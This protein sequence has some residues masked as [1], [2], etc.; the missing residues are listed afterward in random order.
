MN[1][2][3]IIFF[4]IALWYFVGNIIWWYLNTPILCDSAI[5]YGEVFHNIGD[6]YSAPLITLIMKFLL[7]LFGTEYQDLLII[8]V[9]YIF[10][11]I[12]LYFIY[13]IG[14]ELKNKENGCI[15]MLLFALVPAIYGLSRQYQNKD[16]NIIAAIT[17]NVFCLIKCGFF[18]DRKW[19]ILYG[20]SVGLGL[21]IK[22]PFLYYFSPLFCYAIIV[23]CFN[24]INKKEIT[25]ILISAFIPVFISGIHYLRPLIINKIFFDFRSDVV[26]IFEFDSIRVMTLGLSDELLSPPLFILFIISLVFFL[27]E[28]KQKHKYIVLIWLFAPWSM[29][30][31]MGHYKKAAY[32]AGFIPAIVLISAI[33]ISNIKAI[34]FKKILILTILVI[35]IFQYLDF[36]YNT[37]IV[38]FFDVDF[39]YFKYYNKKNEDIMNYNKERFIRINNLI[40]YIKSKYPNKSF[41]VYDFIR[42]PPFPIDRGD[43]ELHMRLNGIVVL[44]DYF[45]SMPNNDN[46]NILKAD[47]ILYLGNYKSC[48]QIYD[49]YFKNREDTFDKLI[50]YTQERLEADYF[51]IEEFFIDKLTSVK[52]NYDDN[53]YKITLLAKKSLFN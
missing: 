18:S 2:N 37:N 33:Y 44:T 20:I 25:N 21:L 32:G 48:A 7:Y 38:K 34:W 6:F 42:R 11:L 1:N 43:I 51:V 31:F 45:D 4:V 24:G 23:R 15:A 29:I 47:M 10:F 16:Y 35:C 30:M 17:F 5:H 19:S 22:D 3:K 50:I 9:N 28:K 8:I 14:V 26:P 39:K 53:N 40:H 41:Y 27:I 46:W 52:E 12:S 49:T 36:S 13:K